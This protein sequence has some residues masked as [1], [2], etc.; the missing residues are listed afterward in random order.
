M[1]DLYDGGDLIDDA[2]YEIGVGGELTDEQIDDIITLAIESGIDDTSNQGVSLP[3]D[4]SF[5]DVVKYTQKCEDIAER[6]NHEMYEALCEIVRGVV[7]ADAVSP[8]TE[9]VTEIRAQ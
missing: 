8:C 9:T 3:R 4:A 6:N 1:D 5:E 7:G 2:L